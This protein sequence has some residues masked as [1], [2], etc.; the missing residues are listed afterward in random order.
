M[1]FLVISPVCE[2]TGYAIKTDHLVGISPTPA[3]ALKD[4]A[5]AE[6]LYD[7]LC[8]TSLQQ[9]VEVLEKDGR[10][11]LN[12]GGFAGLLDPSPLAC[13]PHSPFCTLQSR[14]K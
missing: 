2:T 11:L 1:L 6:G 8:G 7:V 4:P 3:V 14:S 10:A 12:L 5:H 9:V 13:Y